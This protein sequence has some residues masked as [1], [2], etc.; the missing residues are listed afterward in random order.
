MK[1]SIQYLMAKIGK[2]FGRYYY[3]IDPELKVFHT[4]KKEK[5]A[6]IIRNNVNDA[7]FAEAQK[8]FQDNRSFI[9]DVQKNTIH[10]LKVDNSAELQKMSNEITKFSTK[11]IDKILRL[12]RTDNS[13]TN[14]KVNDIMNKLR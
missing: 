13:S 11:K 9:I 10:E 4:I 2:R 12:S 1:T 5:L 14:D 7:V 8:L 6:T 3:S